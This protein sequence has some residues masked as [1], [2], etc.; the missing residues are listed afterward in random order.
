MGDPSMDIAYAAA[1]QLGPPPPL[2]PSLQSVDA[3]AALI[4][5]IDGSFIE[6]GAV[7]D[8][9]GKLLPNQQR[10]FDRRIREIAAASVSRI[11][12]LPDEPTRLN[13]CLRLWAGCLYAAKE[14]REKDVLGNAYTPESRA[15]SFV[16]IDAVAAQDPIFAA[17]VEAALGFKRGR[18]ETCHVE[19]IPATSRA[20]RYL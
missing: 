9:N 19:G 2:P 7:L 13:L 14:M 16:S 1:N 17:G 12:D 11:P 6:T 15:A 8:T 5:A 10:V 3:R 4:A 20:L 18:G